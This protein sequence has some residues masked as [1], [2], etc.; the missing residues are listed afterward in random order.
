MKQKI[1]DLLNKS[2][3]ILKKIKGNKEELTACEKI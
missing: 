3:E 2:K 1:A